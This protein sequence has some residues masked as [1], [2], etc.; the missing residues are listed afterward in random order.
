MS[1][2]IND[3]KIGL[4]S[5]S[6][7]PLSTLLASSSGVPDESM[8]KSTFTPYSAQQILVSGLIRGVGRPVATWSWDVMTR[9][10]RDA[11]R[12][13]CPGQSASV[14]IRTKTM[15]SLDSY[16]NYS[17]V[18]VWPT[19]DEERD[20]ERRIKLKLTFQFLVPS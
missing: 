5:G 13:Y 4:T 2:D 19:Q 6:M 7:M 14:Y 3:F 18:L 9:V 11:L 10:H 17:A 15:D 12:A 8:P 1:P 20:T 16:V